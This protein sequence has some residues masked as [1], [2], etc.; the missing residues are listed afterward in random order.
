MAARPMLAHP[1][2][3]GQ[4]LRSQPAGSHDHRSRERT[5]GLRRAPA[6]TPA[7]RCRPRV[8]RLPRPPRAGWRTARS[9]PRDRREAHSP[10]GRGH[11]P[12]PRPRPA[13]GTA[14]RRP[15]A[16]GCRSRACRSA[17][18]PP[19][20]GRPGARARPA[21]R[22]VSAPWAHPRRAGLRAGRAAGSSSSSLRRVQPR[23]TAFPSATPA[24]TWA[25][26]PG[27]AAR[28]RRKPMSRASVPPAKASP[29]AQVRARTDA[30][31]AEQP[32]R[33]LR[34]VG[35]D[36]FAD[37]GDLV[38]EGHLR[39]RGKPFS[40][41][42]TIPADSTRIH[43]TSAPN[44]ASSS[45]SS[46]RSGSPRTPATIRSGARK[47]FQGI[48]QAQVLR[49]AGEAQT[50]V[51]AGGGAPR[52]AASRRCRRQLRGDDRQRVLRK[53]REQLQG[54]RH[55]PLDVGVVVVVDRGV[56]GHP[57]APRAGEPP[58][59]GREAQACGVARQQ[60]GESRL[61][62]RRAVVGELLDDA[63]VRIDPEHL[64]AGIGQ[65]G[66]GHAPEMPE[67]EHA[68]RPV[69]CCD[70]PRR[71]HDPTPRSPREPGRP[72]RRSGDRPHRRPRPASTHSGRRAG[73]RAEAAR[74]RPAP[75]R[76]SAPIRLSRSRP[77]RGRGA[78]CSSGG[79]SSGHA[80]DPQPLGSMGALPARPPELCRAAEDLQREEVPPL[81]PA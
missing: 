34:G 74:R 47:Q 25:G 7:S 71:C 49:D 33:D 59:V 40:A 20:C 31:L 64:V 81:G 50:A 19:P 75:P 79:P 42:L 37:G 8:P 9:A 35:P 28:A 15:S 53:R 43:C 23:W 17:P 27:L 24:N 5:G 62:Y 52:L 45:A 36:R 13:G 60:L 16:A 4:R 22:A 54:M 73:R 14:R 57:R 38:G 2:M 10:P 48:P 12:R 41:C 67:A 51:A 65:A 63:R 78:P 21:R 70:G 72:H 66:R 80:V 77:R 69:A 76:R 26:C 18:R 1:R 39:W 44:G 56:E 30:A 61:G 32:A 11:A 55:D 58:G 29:G 46:R 6:G 3:A 68:D